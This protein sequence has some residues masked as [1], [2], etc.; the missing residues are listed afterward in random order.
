MR[1]LMATIARE[2]K[3]I[4]RDGI[5]IYLTVSPALLAMVFIFIFGSVQQAS[6][7]FVVGRSFP[8]A[9]TARLETVA[10]IEYADDLESLKKRVRGADSVAGVYWEDGDVKLIVEGNE[11]QG[12]SAAR[13]HL[14]SA[15]LSTDAIAYTSEAIQGQN[16]LAY[17]LG[18]A[19]VFLLALFVGGATL[20]LNGVNERESGV[21]RAMSISPMTLV[22]YVVSKIIPAL[23]FGI[24]GVTL[25]ALI[26]G[27]ADAAPQFILLALC[28][29]FV[30]GILIFLIIAFADNQIAAVGV[31]KILMPLFL[32]VG[33]SAAFIPEKW[34]GFYYALPMYWQ[35]AA[36]VAIRSNTAPAFPM[37]MVLAT[38]IPWFLAVM[39]VFTGKTKIKTWR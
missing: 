37:L 24:V 6:I 5:P 34:L 3:L 26:T 15:A 4:F 22:H 23:L 28:S 21:I 7:S 32:V 19:C 39:L 11:A 17:N 30:N 8:Q 33:I 38:G 20:G 16:A 14:L 13:Q 36:I 10:D 25:C 2:F 9:L 27:R 18:L 31:L 12:F 35:Y 1:G 29:V